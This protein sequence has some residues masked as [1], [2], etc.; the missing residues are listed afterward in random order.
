[1][2]TCLFKLQSIE[3]SCPPH[4]YKNCHQC[5]KICESWQNV[6]NFN[7]VLKKSMNR[8]FLWY[9]RSIYKWYVHFY[10][11]IA[12]AKF[13][14][15]NYFTVQCIYKLMENVHEHYEYYRK[16]T[17]GNVK[18]LPVQ[19]GITFSTNERWWE[20][21]YSLD[22]LGNDLYSRKEVSL[23]LWSIAVASVTMLPFASL[24]ASLEIRGVSTV[25]DLRERSEEITT[26]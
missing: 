26:T 15:V 5:E 11:Y 12:T 19:W 1:M 24:K 23:E 14:T 3:L 25:G 10:I 9:T 4:M 18:V 6:S 8:V 22:L 17:S 7:G 20:F 21:Y 13:S 2:S 16:S